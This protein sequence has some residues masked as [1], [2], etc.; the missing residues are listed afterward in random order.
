VKGHHSVVED[1]SDTVVE[2][3]LAEDEE[4]ETHVDS[5][6]LENCKNCNL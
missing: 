3:G 2:E 5:D 1:D 4:V 6:L